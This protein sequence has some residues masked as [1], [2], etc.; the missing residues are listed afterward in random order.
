MPAK[1]EIDVLTVEDLIPAITK[2]H[3]GMERPWESGAPPALPGT[4]IWPDDQG[5]VLYIG[6]AKL[7]AVRLGAEQRWVDQHDPASMWEVTVIHG[8]KRLGA[9]LDGSRPPTTT[10]PCAWSGI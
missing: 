5:R 2:F 8:L 7:L 4:Y 6:S 3:N 10:R 1:L 9:T